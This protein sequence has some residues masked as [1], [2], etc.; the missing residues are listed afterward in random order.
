MVCSHCPTLIL[1]TMCSIVIC[2]T[3]HAAPRPSL[4]QTQMQLGFK[5]ILSADNSH[6]PTLILITMCS[7]V[8]CRTVQRYFCGRFFL[9][10]R[11]SVHQF[12]DILR[13]IAPCIK[14]DTNF[15]QSIPAEE[16]LCL[17]I[18]PVDLVSRLLVL[19]R[20]RQTYSD[21]QNHFFGLICLTKLIF[22]TGPPFAFYHRN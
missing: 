22:Q 11:M 7:I 14:K 6:C 3:V 15:R 10:Y 12:D 19:V 20:N 1:I 21:L 9:N 8:I 18:R 2:R 16:K 17:K 5:P 13:R 4:T